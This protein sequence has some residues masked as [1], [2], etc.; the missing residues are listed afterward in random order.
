M[1]RLE[2]FRCAPL[3]CWLTR[4]SCGDRSET[5]KPLCA[6]CAVGAQHARGELPTTWP[7][8]API[9]LDV[10]EVDRP[11]PPPVPNASRATTFQR[12]TRAQRARRAA[13]S[14]AVATQPRRG[15]A[16]ARSIAYDGRTVSLSELARLTGIHRGALKHRIEQLGLS[17]E[18]AVARGR[19]TRHLPKRT[20]PF[21]GREVGIE[22]L[23]RAAGV[24]QPTMRYRLYVLGLTPEA[25]VARKRRAPSSGGAA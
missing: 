17:A 5:R 14:N 8:G 21:D 23:A 20:W 19:D 4:E 18:E 1:I 25:A 2:V 22:E 11:A 7:D 9:E 3:S 15:P 6:T 13:V 10:R 24:T 16:N 12:Q